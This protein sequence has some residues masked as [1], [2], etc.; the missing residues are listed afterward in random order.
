MKT[1]FK[2]LKFRLLLALF[3]I[4]TLLFYAFGYSVIYTMKT[5][6][7]QSIEA[8]LTAYARDLKHDYH[9]RMIASNHV[10]LDDITLEFDDIKEEFEIPILY[11]QLV[12][13]DT[14]TQKHI[15]LRR[16]QDLEDAS[17]EL[18]PELLQKL[19][20]TPDKPSFFESNNK[21][22]TQHRIYGIALMIH[23]EA[24][25]SLILQCAL[26]YDKRTPQMKEM[27]KTLIFGLSCLLIIILWIAYLFI[28][29]SFKTILKITQNVHKISINES[30]PPLSKTHIAYEIDYLIETFNTLLS[31]LQKSYNQVKQFGQN[32][33][34][35]LKT[36]LTIIQGEIEVGLRKQRSIEEY[37]AILK[38]I[39][40]E[41]K[42]LHEVIEK[43]L[44]L[45]SNTKK[46]LLQ[47][48]EEVYVDEI[49][50]EVIEDKKLMAQNYEVFIE[51]DHIEPLSVQSNALLL[52][53]A[54][55]NLLD[56]AIK[57]ASKHSYI[58]IGLKNKML[59]ITNENTY[60]N[61]Q[62]ISHLF[63]PFYRA[64]QTKHHVKGHGLG[65]SLVKNILDLHP[66]KLT[67]IKEKE[68]LIRTTIFF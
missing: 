20:S 54:I 40:Q 51:L 52:K 18:T 17:L 3:F 23:Q 11:T 9:E 5:S 66:F 64:Q 57:Y 7:R 42:L 39:N 8:S 6:Y 43:I 24:N 33:S 1:L 26:P 47:H 67:I 28:T 34:H 22:F 29:A 4:L 58:H 62:D 2:N 50:L 25:T 56:N 46:E 60:L 59:Y 13:Y 44:F 55:T 14:N 63:E 16:S 65:L 53:V 48:F 19:L 32:A 12:S 30:I 35:E 27:K 31:E 21:L 41:V 37:Q 10:N 61:E 38:K 49:I 68:S 36:P 15:V 45:S